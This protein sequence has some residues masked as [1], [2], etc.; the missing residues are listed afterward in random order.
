MTDGD[1]SCGGL[2]V[3]GSCD[4]SQAFIIGGVEVVS[5][6]VSKVYKPKPIF[7]TREGPRLRTVVVRH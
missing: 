6:S 3:V 5:E 7:S 2:D 4:L 1:K